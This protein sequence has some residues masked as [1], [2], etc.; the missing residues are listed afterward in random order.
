MAAAAAARS[1]AGAEATV[2]RQ[3]RLPQRQTRPCARRCGRGRSRR[4]YRP[5]PA[6]DAAAEDEPGADAG[7][8]LDVDE[9]AGR[10]R[11]APNSRTRRARRGSRRCR[12]RRARRAARA[13]S[14]AP[15]STPVQPGRIA[16]GADAC[17][18]AVDRPGQRPCRTPID[19]VAGRRPASASTC[20]S[21]RLR[22][23]SRPLGRRAVDV[24]GARRSA[25]TWREVGDGDAEVG[26]PEVDAE[27]QTG[28]PIEREQDGGRPAPPLSRCC[29]GPRARRRARGRRGRRRCWRR[30]SARGRWAARCPRGSRDPARGGRR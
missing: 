21:T 1:S 8:D 14:R 23:R 18:Y 9:V 22:G 25:S 30:S 5:C 16:G 13:S 11:P 7:G 17:R 29:P 4:P 28:R 10:P 15:A 2:S 19:A 6:V 27:G 24:E 12:R 3:P 20:W 26:V